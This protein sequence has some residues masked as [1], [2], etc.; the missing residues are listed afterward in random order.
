MA[1][2]GWERWYLAALVLNK[3]FFCY[4]VTTIAD[5]ECPEWC[6][7]SVYVSPEELSALKRVLKYAP[8]KSDFVRAV[9][10]D[11]TIKT[12]LSEDMYSVTDETVIDAENFAVDEAT[13]EV[14]ES[15]EGAE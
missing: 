9:A 1:V 5:D 12:K 8:L 6:E 7:S 15:A 3:A 4:Q 11:E 14:V 2:T 13:G 10:Q